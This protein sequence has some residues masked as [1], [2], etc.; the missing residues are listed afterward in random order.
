VGVLQ[1][2]LRV[3][4]L[5]LGLRSDVQ[6]LGAFPLANRTLQEGLDWLRVTATRHGAADQ[7]LATPGYDLPPHPVAEGARLPADLPRE[8]LRELSGWLSIGFARLGV[9]VARKNSMPAPRL[10]PHHLDIGTLVPVSGDPMAEDGRSILVGLSLGDDGIDQPYVYVS[11]WP[12]PP[13]QPTP[14]LPE[15]MRWHTGPFYGAVLEGSAWD[16]GIR[17]L[18]ACLDGAIA[19][20]RGIMGR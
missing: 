20:C 8:A 12:Y 7:A 15:G 19:A 1:A 2:T 16:G 18:D 17:H 13:S 9:V 4:D 3:S 11:P 14:P 6:A 10:W 5:T